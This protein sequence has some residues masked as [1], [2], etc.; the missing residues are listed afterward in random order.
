MEKE[1]RQ[2]IDLIKKAQKEW[3]GWDWANTFTDYDGELHIIEGPKIPDNVPD[4]V[5]EEAELYVLK[6]KEDADAAIKHGDAAIS[7]I[8]KND[9]KTALEELEEASVVE[10]NWGSD[11]TWGDPKKELEKYID[12]LEIR[13]DYIADTQDLNL[14]YEIIDTNLVRVKRDSQK[15]VLNLL[16]AVLFAEKEGPEEL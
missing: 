9:L 10:R 12:D 6:V 15:K 3:T 1:Q 2:I 8:K 16:E 13:F 7:A 4:E 11:P 5:K 14:G